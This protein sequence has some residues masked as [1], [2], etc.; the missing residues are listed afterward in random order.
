MLAMPD[1]TTLGCI[2]NTFCDTRN[3]GRAINTPQD[4]IKQRVDVLWMSRRWERK[5][6]VRERE[7]I[8]EPGLELFIV[9]HLVKRLNS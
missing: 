6:R 3:I 8:G 7:K 5:I 4:T 1:L 9:K 2:T